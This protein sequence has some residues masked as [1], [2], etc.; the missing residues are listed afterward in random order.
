MLSPICKAGSNRIAARPADISIVFSSVRMEFRRSGK[1]S[2]LYARFKRLLV[3]ILIAVFYLF[4]LY[5]L[6]SLALS[7]RTIISRQ[8]C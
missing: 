5:A 8:C 4:N 1:I 6:I 3:Y 2:V 7:L